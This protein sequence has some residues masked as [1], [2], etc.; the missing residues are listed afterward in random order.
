M[1]ALPYGRTERRLVPRHRI[2]MVGRIT[3]TNGV[4][5]DCAVR[6]FSLA[7]AA[8]WL[9]NALNLPMKFDP[10]FDNTTRHCIV[11]WRRP[12]WMGVRFKWVP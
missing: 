6:N 10:H 12:Y 1:P 5:V 9:K 2:L 4:L 11:V 3:L 7:G 8:V